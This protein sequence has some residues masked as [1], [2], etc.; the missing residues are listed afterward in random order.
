[1]LTLGLYPV[2]T[3]IPTNTH[4]RIPSYLWPDLAKRHKTESLRQMA[5]EYGVSHE[6]IRQTLAVIR[7]QTKLNET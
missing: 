3:D 2:F 1:L 6:A 4:F 5:K 7:S